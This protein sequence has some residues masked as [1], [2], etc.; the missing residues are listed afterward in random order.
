MQQLELF[1]ERPGHFLDPRTCAAAIAAALARGE[2]VGLRRGDEGLEL[3]VLTGPVETAV[4]RGLSRRPVE[5]VEQALAGRAGA[6]V[7]ARSAGAR[8]AG[9]AE[10]G[11]FG[12]R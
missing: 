7:W 12:G 3:V 10:W 6:A 1:G 2:T 5:I 11:V 8:W 4:P 9:W